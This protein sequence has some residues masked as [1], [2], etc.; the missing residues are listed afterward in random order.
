MKYRYIFLIKLFIAL[1]LAILLLYHFGTSHFIDAFKAVRWGW[2][3]T[4]IFMIFSIYYIS[5]WRLQLLLKAHRMHYGLQ[6]LAAYKLIGSF[7]NNLLPGELGSDAACIYYTS[8]LKRYEEAASAVLVHSMTDVFVM[9]CCVLGG[10]SAI[11]LTQAADSQSLHFLIWACL[12]ITVCAVTLYA[13]TWIFMKKSSAERIE[14]ITFLRGRSFGRLKTHLLR[15]HNAMNAYRN[16]G[17]AVIANLFYSVLQQTVLSLHYFCLA[18]AMG[19]PL[20]KHPF[21]YALHYIVMVQLLTMILRIPLTPGGIGVRAWTLSTLRYYFGFEMTSKGAAQIVVMGWIHHSILLVMGFLGMLLFLYVFIITGKRPGA[22]TLGRVSAAQTRQD[23]RPMPSRKLKIGIMLRHLGAKG[24]ITVYSKSL[25]DKLLPMHQEAE[26][27]LFYADE[28]IRGLYQRFSNVREIVI[29][30]KNRLVWDQ[31]DVKRSAEALGL[32]IVY[33]PKLS[34]PAAGRF[35]R[36]F[37]MQ[38]LEQ[39]AAQECFS[40]LDRLYFGDMTQF[41]C[42][43]ADAV[44]CTNETG[45]KELQQYLSMP[46]E[47]IHIVPASYNE[48]CSRVTDQALLEQTRER[49]GLPEKYILFVGG[50][51]PLK[52]IPVLAEAFKL[53]K[54]NGFPHKLVLVGFNRWGRQKDIAFMEDPDLKGSIIFP[55]FVDDKD[56]SSVYSAADCFVLPSLYEGFGLP[57]LEAQA[58]GCPVVA[59]DRGAMPEVAGGGALHCEARDPSGFANAIQ[60]VITDKK[61]RQT[62]VETGYKNIKKYSWSL[63]AQAM[64]KFFN[65]L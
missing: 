36:V 47:K 37:T 18:M 6:R 41:Y 29:T 27:T 58:C 30:R 46:P 54:A 22:K 31:W 11:L 28:Q 4:S 14:S 51:T 16:A 62:L 24:G 52:N 65:S 38:G 9:V 2:V 33:N 61:T 15:F 64:I 53:I 44:L 21:Q 48:Q 17:G 7:F 34:V 13:A 12:I 32:H 25:L 23:G 49:L 39:F 35:M 57:I 3:F 60:S 59:S 63:S 5:A 1:T 10:G 42:T 19:M 8:G 56:L 45:R 40:A 50:I 26:Y 55:G 20:D 43:R